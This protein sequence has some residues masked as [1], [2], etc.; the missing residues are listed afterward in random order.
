MDEFPIYT[1]EE[2]DL[3]IP[4]DEQAQTPLHE[5]VARRV[6]FNNP[7]PVPEE[8]EYEEQEDERELQCTSRPVY[9][10]DV[11]VAELFE[12]VVLD[13]DDG[14]QENGNYNNG[15][16]NMFGSKAVRNRITALE[17]QNQR[18]TQ[19]LTASQNETDNLRE[20]YERKMEDMTSRV[21]GE[22]TKMKSELAELNRKH[23]EELQAKHTAFSKMESAD[24]LRTENDALILDIRN[25]EVK[26]TK[27]TDDQGGVRAELSNTKLDLT[28]AR[29][30][31]ARI[32]S[33]YD[34]CKA[35]LADKNGELVRLKR[36]VEAG[37]GTQDQQVKTLTADK[38]RLEEQVTAINLDC[39]NTKTM[40]CTVSEFHFIV[41]C[42]QVNSLKR[43]VA[44]RTQQHN[45]LN[46]NIGALERS[47]ALLNA[48]I[49]SLQPQA[50]RAEALDRELHQT[51]WRVTCL[52]KELQDATAD[53]KFRIAQAQQAAAMNSAMNSMYNAPPPPAQRLTAAPVPT[54]HP[55]YVPPAPPPAQLLPS[56][57]QPPPPQPAYN[58]YNSYTDS[59]SNSNNGGYQNNNQS[60]NYQASGA[61]GSQGNYPGSVPSLAALAASTGFGAS[62]NTNHSHNSSNPSM[63]NYRPASGGMPSSSGPPSPPR[64]SASAPRNHT[65]AHGQQ[66]HSQGQG[67]QMQ[68]VDSTAS[69]PF[70]TASKSPFANE[71]TSAQIN[72]VFDELDRRLTSLMTE[73]T[74]LQDESERCVYV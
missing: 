26:C 29:A 39:C 62:N 11:D 34:T 21:D 40:C 56:R 67:Q 8:G 71:V 23:L 12:E 17:I 30:E 9:G 68:V 61:R 55:P 50:A 57:S 37:K 53:F 49:S 10:D 28:K 24:K 46:A 59:S 48:D 2:V 4:N 31:M 36:E 72:H 18:L 7:E 38:L 54:Y 44:D 33:E 1:L 64:R 45:H 3:S 32:K 73:K 41:F 51:K 58:P 13:E 14:N 47:T 22:R 52:E 25:L 66:G 74:T 19:L 35:E 16:F 6:I 65:L 63:G 15:G 20:Q 60:S 70:G 43:E 69:A 42:V 5:Q 27:L